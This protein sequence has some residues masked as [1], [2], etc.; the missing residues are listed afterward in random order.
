M[1]IWRCAPENWLRNAIAYSPGSVWRAT[2]PLNPADQIGLGD[3]LLLQAVQN[4]RSRILLGAGSADDAQPVRIFTNTRKLVSR[5]P[6]ISGDTFFFENTGHAIH[7][8]RPTALAQRVID[9]LTN[10]PFQRLVAQRG[11]ALAQTE[12]GDGDFM[13]ADFDR[14]NVPD[15][16]YIKRR[17][18]GSSTIEIQVVGGTSA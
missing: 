7:A 15:L 10:G 3:A 5:L 13:L 6:G 17:N 16:V 18:T 2:P 11:T 1:E 12:D 8:E 9:F 14:D 4:F